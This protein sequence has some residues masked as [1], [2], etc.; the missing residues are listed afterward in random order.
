MTIAAA[1]SPFAP[2]SLP[3][4]RGLFSTFLSSLRSF[5]CL[6]AQKASALHRGATPAEASAL[7]ATARLPASDS[8]AADDGAGLFVPASCSSPAVIAAV[9]AAQE[10]P[11][12]GL[13]GFAASLLRAA[14]SFAAVRGGYIY[15]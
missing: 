7:A 8:S 15:S 5:A 3:P 4:P 13:H 14:P 2:L 1:L 10:K 11:T 12:F 6:P 9:A